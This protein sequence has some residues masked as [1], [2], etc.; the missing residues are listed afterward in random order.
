MKRKSLV[1]TSSL[2][3]LL[4]LGIAGGLSARKQ[5][6]EV[7]ADPV[8]YSGSIIIQK[9]SDHG[10]WTSRN[11]L[12]GYLFNGSENTWGTPV[13]N[14]SG[15]YQEYSWSGLEFEPTTIIILNVADN[16]S[17]SWENPW[18]NPDCR[19][20]NVTLSLNDVVWMQ[21]DASEGA[22]WGAYS[23][24][25]FVMSDSDTRLGELS[26]YKVASNGASI[27]AFG[28]VSLSANQKFYIQ[29]TIDGTNK[30]KTYT[31]LDLISSN[32]SNDGDYIKVIDA[33]TYEFYFNFNGN[34][35]YLTDPVVA[36][37]DE[38]SQDF[39]KTGCETTSTGTKAKWG[40]HAS[41]F[42]AYV[43]KHGSAFSD[44]FEDEAHVDHKET[45]SGYIAQAV[46]R[47]DYVLELYGV[48]N[49]N[50][51]E[52]GYQD[53]IGRVAAHMVTPKQNVRASIFGAN[54]IENNGLLIIGIVSL[55]AVSAVG[56]YFLL[57]KKKQNN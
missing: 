57:R 48:S 44:I 30:Y 10:G 55:L 52:A 53:F 4:G 56:G 26:H 45:A 31:C 38:W 28:E 1:I 19:S 34:T 18:Y 29:K 12:V 41:S 11:K 2:A 17:S 35:L 20:G 39:L 5:A 24:E 32:L 43:T 15:T 25:T 42:A 8:T 9:N 49:A 14:S 36:D 3:M 16:W 46:Q 47:Y 40:A 7:K 27:E 23:M 33:A 21:K 22:N 54:T 37:A 51:D 13:A 50:T 6:K